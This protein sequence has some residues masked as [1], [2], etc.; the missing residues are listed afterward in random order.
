MEEELCHSIEV[1]VKGWEQGGI[2]GYMGEVE[3]KRLHLLCHYDGIC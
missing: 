1:R 2:G 3:L